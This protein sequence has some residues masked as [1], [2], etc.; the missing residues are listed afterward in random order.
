M[1]S[2]IIELRNAAG[3]VIKNIA[4]ELDLSEPL[5]GT[6]LTHYPKIGKARH[7][8]NKLNS[9]L[10]SSSSDKR[11]PEEV[12][13]ERLAD[14]HAKVEEVVAKVPSVASAAKALTGATADTDAEVATAKSVASTATSTG[15]AASII[16]KVIEEVT[17]AEI[18]K[19]GAPAVEAVNAMGKRLTDKLL[20]IPA[21][22]KA[23]TPEDAEV[24]IITA[25][26]NIDLSAEI[27]A[28][29]DAVEKAVPVVRARGPVSKVSSY[30]DSL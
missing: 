1:R 26:D 7:E 22:T 12:T 29:K 18:A 28:I 21:I 2:T 15:D 23:A 24:A 14:L 9:R 3:K 27:K 6:T 17:S 11:T 4:L 5:T 8:A 10:A 25:L 20:K 30:I 13:N 16:E 19:Y